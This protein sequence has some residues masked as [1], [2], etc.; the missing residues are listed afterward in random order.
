VGLVTWTLGRAVNA[1]GGAAIAAP[2]GAAAAET[3]GEAAGTGAGAVVV[4][5]G[6]VGVADDAGRASPMTPTRPSM[7]ATLNAA[8]PTR[9]RPAT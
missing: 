9:D 4:S 3:A 2:R 8:T 7:V 5:A 6:T 1:T